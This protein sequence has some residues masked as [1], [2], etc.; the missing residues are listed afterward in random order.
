MSKKNLGKRFEKEVRLSL[1]QFNN[2]M[3]RHRLF[4]HRFHDYR[5][6]IPLKNK[7]N[8]EEWEV[9]KQPSDWFIIYRGIPRLLEAKSSKKSASF[10]LSKV[11]DESSPFF[12]Q[13]AA[14]KMFEN[15]GGLSELLICKRTPR[16]N[17]AYVIPIGTFM[18]IIRRAKRERKK[19]VK[20]SYFDKLAS[21]EVIIRLD[22]KVNK[23]WDFSFLEWWRVLHYYQRQNLTVYP[24]EIRR[25]RTLE[26][27]F[28]E[29]R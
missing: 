8:L 26:S 14:M 18:N 23:I 12:F 7:L 21:R 25:L 29:S 27:E 24:Q 28:R 9:P 3:G 22:E 10:S 20:W 4:Y 16:A 6:M 2:T 1:Q 13:I 19:S 11:M 17:V 15:C 5:T